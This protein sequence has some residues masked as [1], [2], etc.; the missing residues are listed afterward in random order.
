M[1]TVQVALAAVA[2]AILAA[3]F[4]QLALRPN[5]G[6]RDPP[7]LY[8]RIPFVGHLIGLLLHGNK[9]YSITRYFLAFL[10]LPS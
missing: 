3:A 5:P 9:Y 6:P 7:V 2:A 8:H 4:S 1:W 10:F